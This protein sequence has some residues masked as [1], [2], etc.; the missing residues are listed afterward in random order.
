MKMKMKTCLY[1]VMALTLLSSCSQE[2]IS[3]NKQDD[4]KHIRMSVS[5]FYYAGGK[6]SSDMTKSKKRVSLKHDEVNN[7]L[8]FSWTSGDRVAVF[9]ENSEQQIGLLM[10][11][12]DE[13]SG[14]TAVF[15]SESYLLVGGKKYL[16]YYPAINNLYQEQVIPMD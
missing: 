9:G 7:K 14:L 4:M 16:A 1:A 8:Q 3:G 11:S 15:D 6:E 13:Q 12:F 5:D 10:K 2:D